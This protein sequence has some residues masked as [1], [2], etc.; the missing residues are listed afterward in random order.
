MRLPGS[1]DLEGPEVLGF[2]IVEVMFDEAIDA[3]AARSAAKALAEFV[4]VF[5]GAGGDNFDVAVFGVADPAAQFQLAGLALHEPAESDSL[6]AAADE[7]V[8][9]HTL[10]V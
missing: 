6:D 2:F 3:A 8:K 10:P 5:G 9:N 4:E 1:F 7:E